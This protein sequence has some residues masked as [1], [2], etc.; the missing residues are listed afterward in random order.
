M[1]KDPAKGKE[2]AARAKAEQTNELTLGKLQESIRVDA[3]LKTARRLLDSISPDSVY[4]KEAQD[5]FARL[6]RSTQDSWR[7]KAR[8]IKGKC[9]ELDILYKQAQAVGPDA[10]DAVKP[11]RCTEAPAP[12]PAPSCTTT[13]VDPKDKKCLQQFCDGHASDARCPTTGAGSA[14]AC[15]ADQLMKEG[16]QQWEIGLYMVALTKFEAAVHC[17]GD[18]HAVQRGFMAACK[19][20]NVTKA[21]LFWRKLSEADKVHLIGACVGQGITRDMLDKP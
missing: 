10:A 6:E 5:D 15:D 1:A 8:A 4:L 19:L 12:P 16:D 21:K 13:L 14:Q 3:N 7:Q 2:F 9:P 20:A 18:V 17:R 11:F